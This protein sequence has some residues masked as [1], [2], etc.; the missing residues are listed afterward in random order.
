MT[1]RIAFNR[2]DLYVII[3]CLY[4]LSGVL[5]TTGLFNRILQLVLLFWA[6]VVSV[7]YFFSTD[8][9]PA[10]V[11][12]TALLVFMYVVY[13]SLNIAFG[14]TI[15]I[16]GSF[17]APAVRKYSY[18]Q[19]ALNSLLPIFVFAEYGKQGVLTKSRI[20]TYFFVFLSIFIIRYYANYN[21]LLLNSNEE[22][23]TNNIG[24][25]FVTLFPFV[26]FFNKRPSM[27]YL[28]ITILMLFIM[29]SMKRGAILIGTLCF[30]YFLYASLK[31]AHSAKSKIITIV[32]T[33]VLVAGAIVFVRNMLD[34]SDYF[35][36]RVEQT[37]AGDTSG[38]NYIYSTIYDAIK[39]EPSV[40]RDIFGRGADST[41]SI[42]GN[43]AHQDW[44]ET[45]CNNGIIGVVLLFAFYVTF[46]KLLRRSRKISAPEMY[47]ACLTL[48]IISIL[49][50]SFSMS[51]QDMS[52]SQTMLLGYF[53]Y[54]NAN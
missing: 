8:K 47:N 20:Q 5:Y 40:I 24:Y 6:L 2:C 33:G 7:K 27:Q 46:F 18:L 42:A 16:L 26:F 15:Y 19:N 54:N 22:E 38:R 23:F 29:M 49:R 28:F 36:A 37:K 39:S 32:L 30:V 13:G 1:G 53:A 44:L 11:K 9:K 12:A 17:D 35:Y 41:I 21:A 51:I 3:G 31:S 45:A 25:S 14:E 43:Y 4:Q 34:N 48:F 52:L 50:T 10:F